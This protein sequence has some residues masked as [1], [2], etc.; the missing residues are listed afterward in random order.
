MEATN[1]RGEKKHIVVL[2][3]GIRTFGAWQDRFSSLLHRHEPGVEVHIYKYGYFSSLAFLIPFLRMIVIRRFREYLAGRARAWGAARVDIV[4]HSFGTYVTA[5]ALWGLPPENRPQIDTLIL[6]GSVLKQ[7]FPWDSLVGLEMPVRRV[8]NDCGTKDIWPVVAQ[9]FA[10]GMGISG[11]QGFAGVTGVDVGIIN[12]YFPVGHSGFFTDAFMEEN[13][14]PVLAGSTPA[15]GPQVIPTRASI[16]AAIEH[17]ADPLK[18]VILILPLAIVAYVINAARLD[19]RTAEEKRQDAEALKILASVPGTTRQAPEK[20]LFDAVAAKA[21]G[22]IGASEAVQ[23]SA[24][25]T[26][27]SWV[28]AALDDRRRWKLGGWGWRTDVNVKRWVH[29]DVPPVYS[30][31]RNYAVLRKTGEKDD[32]E[33]GDAY[34]FKTRTLSFPIMLDIDRK[35]SNYGKQKLLF[36]GFNRAGTR[37]YLSRQFNVEIYTIT[38]EPVDEFYVNVSKDPISYVGSIKNDKM[39]IVGDTTG[40]VWVSR[41]EIPGPKEPSWDTIGS[42]S[43]PLV[44]VET[45]AKDDAALLIHK[46]GN[47]YYWRVGGATKKIPHDKVTFAR[48]L[49]DPLR[50]IFLTIGKDSTAKLWRA[51]GKEISH[52]R[53][54]PL[55]GHPLLYGAFSKNGEIVLTLTDGGTAH[56]WDTSSGKL[57]K[58]LSIS[59]E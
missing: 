23:R 59:T 49:Q 58:S 31:D 14:V 13:W 1:T 6:S 35:K 43:W 12:R 26:L 46:E 10:L 37:I 29:E 22:E 28:G 18:I 17:Y 38:G 55:K 8:I 50:D 42:D 21:A 27:I 45:N 16:L 25:N 24:L 15:A 54:L 3:H 2:V 53:D 36:A 32:R 11:R 41:S 20:V 39:L 7:L 19:A 30:E 56:F 44:S 40:Y 34:V 48:F 47:V 9:L 52:I 33:L 51:S 57:I 5:W 4:A